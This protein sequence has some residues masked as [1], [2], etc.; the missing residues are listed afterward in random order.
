MTEARLHRSSIVTNV[1]KSYSKH[2]RSVVEA[3]KSQVFANA[4]ASAAI[5]DCQKNRHVRKRSAKQWHGG[6][7]QTPE[8]KVGSKS[9]KVRS[10]E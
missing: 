4:G 8:H 6:I 1:A 3:Q 10:W 7:G 2:T 5:S 9:L